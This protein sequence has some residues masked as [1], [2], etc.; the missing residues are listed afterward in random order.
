[1]EYTAVDTGA[2]LA[3]LDALVSASYAALNEGSTLTSWI[4][5][6]AIAEALSKLKTATGSS[7]SLLQFVDD[8]IGIAGK[9][10]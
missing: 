6:P 4:M 5:R 7:Q 8:G 1:M 2:S 3:N 9:P 10:R